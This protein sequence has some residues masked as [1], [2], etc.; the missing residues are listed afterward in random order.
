MESGLA[1]IRQV[2]GVPHSTI[3]MSPAE[4]SRRR[5]GIQAFFRV[6]LTIVS[7]EFDT[8]VSKEKP[9]QERQF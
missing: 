5:R 3:Y 4:E 2:N 6:S 7:K 9:D 1:D 8:F